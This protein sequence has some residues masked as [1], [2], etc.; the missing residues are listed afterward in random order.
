ML[1][2]ILTMSEQW[3]TSSR[4]TA[5]TAVPP[6]C[7]R[8]PGRCCTSMNSCPG[9]WA[10]AGGDQAPRPGSQPH[11]RPREEAS[12]VPGAISPPASARKPFHSVQPL[13]T[14][15]WG[16]LFGRRF[17][18]FASDGPAAERGGWE[19]RL[20]GLQNSAAC[21][22][23]LKVRAASPAVTVLLAGRPAGRIAGYL[24]C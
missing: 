19:E 4:T 3:R 10:G 22:P 17:I 1:N 24:Q 23:V 13:L 2:K 15:P 16:L 12:Q 14:P 18:S 20:R 9:W 7:S 11:P 6:A 21:S 5:G 8:R